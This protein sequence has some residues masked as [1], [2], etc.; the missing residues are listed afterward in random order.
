MQ[1]KYSNGIQWLEFDLFADCGITHGVFLRQLDMGSRLNE[2]E[3]IIT[4]NREQLK[5]TLQLPNLHWLHQVHGTTIAPIQQHSAETPCE[6]DALITN[7]P[8]KALMV[9][10]ADCQATLIYDPVT[11]VVAAVHSGWRGSVQNI[12]SA[13][14]Q[15]LK[16]YGCRAENLLVGISP[17]LGPQNAEFV[18]YRQELPEAFWDYQVRPTYFDFWSISFDQLKA[19]GILPHHIEIARQCTV[20][21]ADDFFSYRRDKSTGRHGTVIMFS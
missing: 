10:H 15:Q 12:Y 14:V 16:A 17:S 6:G 8:G 2:S 9:R 21:N 1:R 7:V 13:V 3:D 19:C 18:N 20:A 5:E 4:T 11:R